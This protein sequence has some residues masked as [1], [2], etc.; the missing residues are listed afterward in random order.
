EHPYRAAYA[1][2]MGAFINRNHFTH[3]LA[4]GLAP[5]VWWTAIS[6]RASN[7]HGRAQ[8]GEMH[9]SK[10]LSA[11]LLLALGTVLFAGLMSLSRGGCVALVIAL[12]VG[13]TAFWRVGLLDTKFLF[14]AA[15]VS[16]L[17]ACSLAVH[18][19]STVSGRLDDLTSG[20]MSQLDPE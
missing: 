13:C 19:Y 9:G 3:F 8:R 4:L 17:L 10:V 7:S 12:G 16:V 6:L 18:G 15:V 2:V 11:I 5:L 20:S 1:N 14:G